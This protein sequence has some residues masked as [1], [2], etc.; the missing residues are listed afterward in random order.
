M[1]QGKDFCLECNSCTERITQDSEQGNQ[2]RHHRPEAYRGPALSAIG[3]ATI[4]FLVRT[5][6][7]EKKIADRGGNKTAPRLIA[8]GNLLRCSA[9]GHPFPADVRP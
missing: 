8:D 1:A 7:R 5:T 9:C 6:V 3:S 2:G 4:E